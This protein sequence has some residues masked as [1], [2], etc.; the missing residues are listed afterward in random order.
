MWGN[1]NICHPPTS[2]IYINSYFAY[3]NV[4]WFWLDF[5][6]DGW[7]ICWIFCCCK[8]A[9]D[10]EH[11]GPNKQCCWPNM[12]DS[13]HFTEHSRKHCNRVYMPNIAV[14]RGNTRWVGSTWITKNK[15]RKKY[16]W[17]VANRLKCAESLCIWL[18]RETRI[19]AIAYSC[20][21][22]TLLI[23]PYAFAVRH[24]Y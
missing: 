13:M 8:I 21:S 3:G 6:H 12:H 22:G 19:A 14:T 15:T 5:Y 9:C 11:C 1:N 7:N 2:R 23:L 4:I 10:N 17:D 16:D 20:V 18:N 24:E